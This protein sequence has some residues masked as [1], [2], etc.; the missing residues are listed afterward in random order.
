VPAGFP[1]GVASALTT[2]GAEVVSEDASAW[3]ARAAAA[4]QAGPSDVQRLRLVGASTAD[5]EAVA[6]ATSEATGGRP[7]VAIYRQPVTGA[8]RIELLPFLREQAV[9]MTA[10]RFGTVNDLPRHALGA[11]QPGVDVTGF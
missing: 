5:V 2:A 3:S 9:S 7:D 1:A 10:H 4:A 8:G 11:V 6:V